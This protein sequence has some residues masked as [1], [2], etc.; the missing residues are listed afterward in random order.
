MLAPPSV[1]ERGKQSVP[2]HSDSFSPASLAVPVEEMAKLCCLEH[3][4]SLVLGLVV[5][6]PTIPHTALASPILSSLAPPPFHFKP[7]VAWGT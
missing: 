1:M 7:R 4:N 3:R 6:V 5:T 2:T